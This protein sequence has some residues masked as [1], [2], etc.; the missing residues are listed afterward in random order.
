LAGSVVGVRI[1]SVRYD[2][3]PRLAIL[4]GQLGY[5]ST[6]QDVRD[7]LAYWTDDPASALFAAADDDDDSLLG[8]AALHIT[9]ILEVTGKFGRLVALVVDD[10]ARGRG[11]GSMLLA[12]VEECARVAGC[13][14][15]EVTSSQHRRPAHL[16]YERRG[17][18]DTRDRSRRFLH[19]LTDPQ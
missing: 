18:R 11:V 3:V 9:P 8:V 17:Y 13:L 4:L 2:D 16:F 14:F 12:A 6:E 1:R 10:T 19:P 5:P 7:R 15:M